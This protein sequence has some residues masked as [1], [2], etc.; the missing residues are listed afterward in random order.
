MKRILV[1]AF[2]GSLGATLSF[3]AALAQAPTG[4]TGSAA[5]REPAAAASDGGKV[6]LL[7]A[8]PIAPEADPVV[9]LVAGNTV[10]G[11]VVAVTIDGA[12]VH[13]DSAV[14]A[15]VPKRQARADRNVE[16]DVVR[17]TAF[18][19][20]QAVATTIVPDN[21]VNASEGGGL[22]RTEKRQLS[23][24]LAADRPVETVVIEA[25]ATGARASL[26][27]RPAYARACEADRNSR[28]C[29]R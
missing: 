23:I 13:L 16:G 11:L 10:D 29:R 28:W 4:P 21:V 24:A 2:L 6:E 25:A 27:V 19:G 1:P 20:G 8:R 15:R 5:Q 9:Q 17:A 3:T 7:P 26:D 12:S 18:A 22:V 14:L